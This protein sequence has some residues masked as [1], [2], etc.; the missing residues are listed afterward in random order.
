V[1]QVCG[2]ITAWEQQSGKRVYERRSR[3][4]EIFLNAVERFVGD[5]LRARA[6]SSVSGRIYRAIGKTAFE[7]DPV[8]YDVFMAMLDGLNALGLVGHRKGQ[9]RYHETGFEPGHKVTVPGRAA[10]FWATPKLVKLAEQHGIHSGNVGD[11]FVP[12][13]PTNPLVL[14]DYATGRGRYREADPS[15]RT[16][17]AR[18]RLTSLNGTSRS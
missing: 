8:N 7:D 1:L 3:S 9:T 18:L 16:T 15:S 12:E 11:H 2:H 13:P 14:K 6:G 5:L 10:R 4:G 17:S